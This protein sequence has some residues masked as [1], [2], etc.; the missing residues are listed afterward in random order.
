MQGLRA[1]DSWKLS[2]AYLFVVALLLIAT[3]MS[4]RSRD[5][6]SPRYG[7]SARQ[8]NTIGVQDVLTSVRSGRLGNF[9]IAL[10]ML[11]GPTAETFETSSA[12]FSA[13]ALLLVTA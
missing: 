9:G 13:A 1:V 3:A 5:A 2:A 10:L 11:V 4:M 6:D 7:L 12:L 8:S